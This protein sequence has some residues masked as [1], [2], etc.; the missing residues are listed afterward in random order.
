[1]TRNALEG[2]KILEYCNMISGPYCTKLMADMGAEVI[3]IE[4]PGEGDLARKKGPFPE[5]I[6]HPEKS[7]LFL[8]LNTNKFGITLDPATE[9]GKEIFYKLVKDVDILIEN[10]PTEEM[11]TLGFG[12]DT[13]KQINPGLIMTSIKP[14]GKSGPYKNYK[15]YSFNIGHA[16][17]QS[18][19]LPIPML[20]LSRAPVKAGGNLSDYDPGLVTVV[21]VMAALFHKRISG[22]GQY[23]E[24]S[25]QEAL[26]SMQRVESVTYANGG[27]SVSRQGNPFG[28][29]RCKDGYV[30][31][32]TPQER[33]WEAFIKLIGNPEWA[34]EEAFKKRASRVQMQNG[35]RLKRNVEE[36]AMK[37]TREEIVKMG[38]EM[39]VPVS[40]VNT[41]EDVVNSEQMMERE[42][43][44]P[45]DHPAVGKLDKFP[46][47]PFKFH[48]TP[49]QLQRPAPLLGQHNKEIFCK[50]LGIDQETLAKLKENGV[51]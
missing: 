4:H 25:K 35:I 43:F 31:I 30:N 18:Y 11:E 49:W 32:I 13:L 28:I 40:S 27:E 7:G 38:Q 8:Y 21:A 1:M 16:S 50:R 26:L 33:Q 51:V 39:R 47:K 3:K 46:S 45:M 5:D 15:A 12:Y 37:Y 20:D 29:V 23:I 17:G 34:Q 44:V 41:A 9:D 48:K 22:R 42:F 2:V 10:K 36:W 19:V 6:S 14:F 24:I